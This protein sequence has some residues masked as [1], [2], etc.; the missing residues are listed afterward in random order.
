MDAIV[1]VGGLG[2]R[3]SGVV[4]DVPKPMAP[5]GDVP[6]LDILLAK[7][8]CHSMVE[9]VV[10]AVGY[11][12]EVVQNYFGDR[13]Y[14][15]K[16]IY[17]IETEPLGTGGGICNALAHTRSAEV[18][19]V[20][21]DTL[22][23]VD[24]AAMVESHRQHQASLTL[25][26]KPMHNFSRYGTVQR[27]GDPSQEK[28]CQRIIGFEEKQPKESGLIN[29]GVYLLNQTLFDGLKSP[30][31]QKFSF[32]TDFLETHLQQLNVY[33]FVSNGYFIDIGVPD[34]YYRAQQELSKPA[35]A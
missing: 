12:R 34:D 25:A 19:V 27:E 18:L 21:G 1:L 24:I 2:T 32:E 16:I 3:L 30:L 14:N 5:V 35:C 15:R 31:P 29:G 23:E 28:L 10:L 7:L 13:A 17:A 8:L 26:L 9:R 4:S 6:F 33:G 11:K 22:F 20:N